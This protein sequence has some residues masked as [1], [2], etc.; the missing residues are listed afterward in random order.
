MGLKIVEVAVKVSVS[1][2]VPAIAVRKAVADAVRLYGTFPVEDRATGEI[3][4]RE[5]TLRGVK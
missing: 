5:M 1:D 3:R 4:H 2:R